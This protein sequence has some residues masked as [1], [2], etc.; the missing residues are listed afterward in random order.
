MKIEITNYFLKEVTKALKKE[1]PFSD[2]YINITNVEVSFI[3]GTFY[4]LEVNWG[5][6][7]RN[8]HKSTKLSFYEDASVDYIKGMFARAVLEAD[9]GVVLNYDN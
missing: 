1:S 7:S 5:C 2:G 3:C 6:E 4:T 9:E 8:I